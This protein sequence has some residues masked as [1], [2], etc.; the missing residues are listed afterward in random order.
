MS[1]Q[2]YVTSLVIDEN[3]EDK[4]ADIPMNQKLAIII[5]EVIA[6][7]EDKGTVDYGSIIFT[8]VTDENNQTVATVIAR[9]DDRKLNSATI[10]GND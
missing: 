6:G 3:F 8:T 2:Q 5:K 4:D 1:Y 7:L 10:C 9:V